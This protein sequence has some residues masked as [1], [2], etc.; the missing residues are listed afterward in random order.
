MEFQNLESSNK[1]IRYLLNVID[2]YTRFLLVAPLA[3]K[4]QQTVLDG[5][6]NIIKSLDQ[7]E[8]M[9]IH[10]KIARKWSQAKYLTKSRPTLN[11]QILSNIPRKHVLTQSCN[12]F[13]KDLHTT[14]RLMTVGVYFDYDMFQKKKK[15]Q[16]ISPYPNI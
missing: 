9:W 7:Q 11:L 13:K 2:I 3:D 8:W 12:Q 15:F 14:T 6:N 5:F 4:E 1:G 16:P 10:S